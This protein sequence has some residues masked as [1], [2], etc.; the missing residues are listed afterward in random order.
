MS[1]IQIITNESRLHQ[2]AQEVLGRE[3]VLRWHWKGERVDPQRQRV[4]AVVDLAFENKRVSF[5]VAYQLTATTLAVEKLAARPGTKPKL[6]IAP[7]LSDAMVDHCRKHQVNCADLNG[8]L[9]IHVPGVLIDRQGT[10]EKRYRPEVMPP[11][12]FQPKSSR[13]VRALLSHP[14][15]RWTHGELVERTGL[16]GGLIS[17]LVKHLEHQGT[18]LREGPPKQ[19]RIALR[20]A[21]ALLDAWV[22]E[23]DWNK[24]ATIRQYSLL[25]ADLE[26]AARRLITAFPSGEPLAF[27][28]W[29]AA[30][31]RHPYTTPPVVSAYVSN[32][33]DEV[34]EKELRARRVVDGGM[35]WLILPNDDGVFRE[36][37]RVGEFVL[38]CD[39]Q[40][41]LDLLQVGL[42]G[43]DQ[44]Q[45]LREWP[46][47]RK[48]KQ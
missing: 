9:W 14:D 15:R 24:R 8:R 38:V 2:A 29:F 13:L 42:R 30:N 41:Y 5:E 17:R 45:A 6:M 16:S 36:T 10:G 4:G 48:T 3:P 12:P 26:E 27:T 28:Q 40:I 18:V 34:T 25:S 19:K 20:Q 39:A 7:S 23:D 44:A 47:F 1:K 11:D 31:F 32:W 46:G 37:Q 22:Q 35:L 43:P 21:D 33:L